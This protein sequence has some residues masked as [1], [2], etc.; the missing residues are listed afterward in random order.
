LKG[1]TSQMENGDKLLVSLYYAFANDIKSKMDSLKSVDAKKKF[2]SGLSNFLEGAGNNSTD[3]QVI[4]WAASTLIKVAHSFTEQGET[5]EA[6][7]MYQAATNVLAQIDA[8]KIEVSADN[9]LAVL[10]SHGKALAGQG[11]YEQAFPKFVQYLSVKPTTLDVQVDAALT[12]QNWGETTDN[13]ENIRQAIMGGGKVTD[14]KTQKTK[15]VIWGWGRLSTAIANLPQF[16]KQFLVARYNLAKSRLIYHKIKPNSRLMDLA[17]KDI[18]VAKK[19]Y[20]DLGSPT[21]KAQFAQ[22]IKDIEAAR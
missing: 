20:P 22:L 8:K 19:K 10:R 11:N 4:M 13:T 2:S 15:N 7:S 12:L 3:F 9:R 16:K 17:I 21:M 14:P 5:T 18:D 6:T 1:V